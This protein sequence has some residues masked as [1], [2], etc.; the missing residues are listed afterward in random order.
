VI[1]AGLLVETLERIRDGT[2]PRIPQDPA[3][4]SYVRKLR[5]SDG[6]ID[7]S[8]DHRRV[9]D[10]VRGTTPWPGA[11]TRYRGEALGVL[12]AAP[13]GGPERRGEPGEVLAIDPERGIEVAAGGGSVWLVR[14]QPAGKRGM[15]AASFV[16]GY[17]LEV[18]ARPFAKV[19]GAGGE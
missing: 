4:A 6:E 7:W 15:D 1:G 8:E 3:R 13:G 17:H 14:V 16:R 2:A 10:R 12:E 5:R 19:E 18:G 11:F 9:F